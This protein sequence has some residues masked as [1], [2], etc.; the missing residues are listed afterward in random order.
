[1]IDHPAEGGERPQ[2]AVSRI[3]A[4]DLE[5]LMRQSATGGLSRRNPRRSSN[6]VGRTP[7][8][9]LR[10]R[11]ELLRD[12]TWQIIVVQDNGLICD[13]V[14]FPP[15]PQQCQRGRVVSGGR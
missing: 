13:G 8:P 2:E 14:R 7:P 3:H 1:M 12:T 5:A 15:E 4:G 10:H 11:A 6:L 9:A